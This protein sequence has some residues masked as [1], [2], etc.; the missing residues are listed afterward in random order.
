MESC[1]I[2]PCVTDLFNLACLQVPY[3]LLQMVG[4]ST[5]LKL[6]RDRWSFRYRL[7]RI[8]RIW[9]ITSKRMVKRWSSDRMTKGNN[10]W[11]SSIFMNWSRER[12][13]QTA[14]GGAVLEGKGKLI[15]LKFVYDGYFF[16]LPISIF[17]FNSLETLSLLLIFPR[18]N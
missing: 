15:S 11:R 14:S 13:W 17:I 10:I 1:S 5:V 16:V 12:N 2:C 4:F 3:M 6:N 8:L 9:R 18:W 7:R